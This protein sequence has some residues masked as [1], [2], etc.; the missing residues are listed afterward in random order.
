MGEHS[1]ETI[2]RHCTLPESSNM[3]DLQ[4]AATST[5][6]KITYAYVLENVKSK[7]D[8]MQAKSS[9]IDLLN[10]VP[11]RR[12][13]ESIYDQ[14][15]ES[16]GSNSNYVSQNEDYVRIL[17]QLRQDPSLIRLADRICGK[18]QTRTTRKQ[19]E[20]VRSERL[21]IGE[22]MTLLENVYIS[23]DLKNTFQ[24]PINE[25]WLNVCKRW[26][27]NK[28]FEE[29][30]FDKQLNDGTG[31]CHNFSPEFQRFIKSIC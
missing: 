26:T 18:R 23:L 12:L 25:G 19:S 2:L 20:L 22:M 3:D 4:G 13:F 6:E 9:A 5:I 17:Q 1:I 30:W 31:I 10:R 11:T 27:G 24:H 15:L 14:W 16:P 7:Q 28:I 29:H 8:Y 21:M